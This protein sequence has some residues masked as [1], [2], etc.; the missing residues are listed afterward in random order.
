MKSRPN[1][2]ASIISKDELQAIT[3]KLDDEKVVDILTLE[4][5]SAELEEA[6]VWATGDG[7]LLGKT[8]HPI[9]VK[10]NQIL[11]ILTADDA[12]SPHVS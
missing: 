3:R 12:E 6:F 5:T 11:E 8:G 1:P 10:V 7:D 4:P 9:S 2:G